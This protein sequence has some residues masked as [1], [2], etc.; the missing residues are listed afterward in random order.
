MTDRLELAWDADGLIDEQRYYCLETPIDVNNLPVPKAVLVGDVRTYIDTE[1]EVGK[2]YYL[3]VGS[4]K[5][6]VEKISEQKVVTA[7]DQ[8]WSSVVCYLRFDTDFSDEKSKIWTANGGVSITSDAKFGGGAL[9]LTTQGSYL[10][11][12]SSSDFYLDGDFTI[13]FFSKIAPIPPNFVEGIWLACGETSWN[14]NAA[15]VGFNTTRM[16]IGDSSG[17]T[18]FYTQISND[19]LHYCFMRESGVI[20]GFKDGVLIGS[21]ALNR[22]FKFNSNG[23]CIGVARWA[24]QTTMIGIIDEM[25]ITKSVARYDTAGFAPPLSQFPNL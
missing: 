19:L 3:R 15:Y 12:P 11:T 22:A 6:G 20:Y 16:Y 4:V 7:G 5:N 9:D 1:I 2:T 25:R 18:L 17:S 10:S 14:S 8:Y 13:E 24:P 23:T 21:E